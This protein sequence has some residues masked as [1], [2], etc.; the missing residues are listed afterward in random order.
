MHLRYSFRPLMNVASRLLIASVALCASL[1]LAKPGFAQE[2]YPAKPVKFVVATPATGPS[3][4]VGTTSPIR[5]R[6]EPIAKPLPKEER[7][8][9]NAPLVDAG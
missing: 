5:K 6:G 9:V 2:R 7:L 4:G 1:P 8:R 3:P